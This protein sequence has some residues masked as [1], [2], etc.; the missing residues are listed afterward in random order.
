[1]TEKRKRR[2]KS[3]SKPHSEEKKP[4][5]ISQKPSNK[6]LFQQWF[7]EKVRSD[8]LKYWQE[9]EILVFMKEKGLSELEDSEK[10]EEML[11]IY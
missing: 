7:G 2:R 6:V 10:Y 3:D 11:R 5:K 8:E 1:M 9:K 4:Q